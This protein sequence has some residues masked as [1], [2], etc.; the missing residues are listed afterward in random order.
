MNTT[1][2]LAVLCQT[3][4]LSASVCFP[5]HLAGI[6]PGNIDPPKCGLEL[7]YVSSNWADPVV[8]PI[9]HPLCDR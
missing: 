6:I 2:C 1:V 4:E 8:C 3:F 9:Y 7:K 5:Y